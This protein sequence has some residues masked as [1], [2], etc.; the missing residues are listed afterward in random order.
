MS[1]WPCRY[2]HFSSGTPSRRAASTDII[3]AAAP[4]FTW[5]RATSSR[6]YGSQIIRLSSVTVTISS[7]ERSTGDDENG[8]LAAIF[9]SGA[10]SSAICCR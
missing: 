8:F 2:T 4:W 3:T 9:D 7:T 5:S 6:G 10:N 1:E